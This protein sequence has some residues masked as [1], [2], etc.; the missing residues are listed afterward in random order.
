MDEKLV[1]LGRKANPNQPHPK[2][3]RLKSNKLRS[4]T[5][6]VCQDVKSSWAKS[7]SEMAN[8]P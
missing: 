6:K 3:I 1:H 8:L 5:E 7:C 4:F 2:G